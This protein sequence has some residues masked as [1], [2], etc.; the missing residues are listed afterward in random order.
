MS[1]FVRP[2]RGDLVVGSMCSKSSA[3]DSDGRLDPNLC[4]RRVSIDSDTI[5][6]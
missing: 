1:M 2:N 6:K 5:Y 3:A 4:Q